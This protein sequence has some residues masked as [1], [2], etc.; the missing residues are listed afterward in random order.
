MWQACAHKPLQTQNGFCSVSLP[1][2]QAPKG[3]LHSGRTVWPRTQRLTLFQHRFLW[4]YLQ[5][6]KDMQ[7]R[8]P[9][10]CKVNMWINWRVEWVL[11]SP[12][13]L[14]SALTAQQTQQCNV[15]ECSFASKCDNQ[16]AIAQQGGW[17]YIIFLICNWW[18]SC[19]LRE[20]WHFPLKAK[21]KM[22]FLSEE[23]Y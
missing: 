17:I 9:D 6:R 13:T 23:I 10:E 21:M 18:L 8:S 19:K 14:K 3:K 1:T 20:M 12:S 7:D 4:N 16:D 2:A 22:G 5:Q 11:W 15:F